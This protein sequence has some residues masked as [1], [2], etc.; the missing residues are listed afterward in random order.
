LGRLI[1]TAHLGHTANPAQDAK[2]TT[3]RLRAAH[4]E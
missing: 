2:A 1:V 3:L 4:T